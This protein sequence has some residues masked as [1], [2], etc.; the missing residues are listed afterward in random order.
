[1]SCVEIVCLEI[2]DLDTHAF[3]PGSRALMYSSLLVSYFY[4]MIDAAYLLKMIINNV[5]I[6]KD[7]TGVTLVKNHEKIKEMPESHVNAKPPLSQ[8]LHL[9]SPMSLVSFTPAVS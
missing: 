3:T 7:N 1:M 2:F 5:L 6:L 9:L 8:R 4:L